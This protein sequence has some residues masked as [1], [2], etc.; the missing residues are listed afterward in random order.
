[1]QLSFLKEEALATP[2]IA[3]RDYQE[4]TVEEV[5]VSNVQRLLVVAPTG[6]GKGVMLGALVREMARDGVLVIQ[7]RDELITQNRDQSIRFG[8]PESWTGVIRSGDNRR[9]PG[10]KAHFASLQT[11]ASWV[12]RGKPLPQVKWILVDEAHRAAAESYQK[13]LTQ[14]PNARVVGF[15]ATP[16]RLDGKGLSECFDDC[17][18]VA[19]IPD[20]IGQGHLC[21]L[22][23]HS[24]PKGPDLSGVRI[25]GGDFAEEDLAEAMC[26]KILLG[27]V[28]QT[29]KEMARGRA[30][31]GFAVN[32]AHA[33]EL[34]A[35]CLS[36]GLRSDVSH[37]KL[38]L[39]VRRENLKRL[40]RGDL[41]IL[42][43]V[44]LHTEGTDVTAVKS[45]LLC[46]P[47]LS[48]ALFFQMVG[49]GMRP[50]ASFS[51][52]VVLDFAG[53]LKIHGHPLEPQEYTLAPPKKRG[54]GMALTKT[55]PNCKQEVALG[56]TSCTCGHIW[57][58]EKRENPIVVPGSLVEFKPRPGLVLRPQDEERMIREAFAAAT[59]ANARVP[60]SYAKAI[61]EKRLRRSPDKA[62]FA[63]VLLSIQNQKPPTP[64]PEWL[65][66]QVKKAP[67]VIESERIDPDTSFEF[68]PNVFRAPGPV[69]EV[70]F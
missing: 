39:S 67:V 20:L 10:A 40:D 18:V 65:A 22:W 5:L 38:D 53:A 51:D 16:W 12:S 14:Y 28:P 30:A 7:H 34:N 15:T 27:D 61:L 24:H 48:P 42:W 36:A 17:L 52:C 49:R 3:L 9:N 54:V 32:I 2:T 50:H 21:N 6:A 58:R 63:K 41:D 4:A 29:Y 35:A 56:A 60:S 19:T 13:I 66:G 64:M 1:M 47:T 46:R 31:L 43:N 26:S 70:S 55:C 68:D 59:K 37:G 69:V 25:K 44:S 57:E 11:L 23:C 8:V 33:Q 62:L 45:I